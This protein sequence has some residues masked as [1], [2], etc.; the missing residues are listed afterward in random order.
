MNEDNLNIKCELISDDEFIGSSEFDFDKIIFDLNSQIDLLSSQADSLDYI[1]AIASGIV[2]GI[3]DI[4]WVGEFDLAHGRSIAS[5]KVDSFVKNTAEML[6]G[7]TFDD[8]KSAVQALEKHF[9]I[10]SDGNT[11]DFGGGKQHHL[12]DFAHHPTIVGLAFSL[13]TQFT[14]KSYGTDVNGRFITVDVPEKSKPFI[15]KD[16]PE[17]ILMGTIIWFFHLVSDIAGS[18]SAAGTTGGTGIPGPLLALAKEVSAIPFFKN[19]KVDD[20]MSMSLFLSKLFNGTLMMKRDEKGQ[21][22]KD[23]IIKFDLRGELGVAV[24]LCKQAVP[25]V[26]N[27]CF[28]RAFYFIRHLAMEMKENRV[29]CF[30]DMKMIDW[31]TVKPLNNPTIARMLTISTGVF[32][33]LDIGEAIATQKYWMSIN[34]VG[35]GRFAVAISSD[36]S[37]GLKARD[38]KKIRGVY[39]NIKHQTFGKTDAN[40]YKRIGDDMDLQMDKLGLSLEQTEILYNLEYYKTF[41]D[42]EMTKLPVTGEVIK[43]LK[44]EWL[45]EWSKFI[46]NGFESFTQI[47]G[48]EMH[49]Y[50]IDELQERIAANDPQK[51]WYRLILLE[52]MLFEPYYP[53]GTEKDKKGNDIPSK[54]YKHLN[55][56]LCSFRKG[57]GDR[58]LDEQFT[59]KYCKQGYVKRLRK[60]YDKRMRE[61]SEVLKTVLASLTI[62]AVI[63]II[64]VASAGA[65]AGPI[66]VALVGSN[67]AGLSG[68][69]LTSACLAYLGGGAIAAG[70]AGMLGGTI[71][72]VGGGAALG[73]GVGAGVG[74]A[75]GSAGLVGKKN[76][77]MQS[78]KLLTSVREIFLNDE[79]DIEFSNSV[80]EQYL[81]NITE[82]EKGLVELRLKMDVAKGKEKKEIA[83]TIKKAEESVEVMKVARKNMLRFNSSFAEG[84][85]TQQ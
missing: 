19:I 25:V 52:A 11:S 48:A 53:L 42:I 39:E 28:V 46:S 45:K 30:A 60:S 4:L 23:S 41:N 64:T 34:Y 14:E 29:V 24:E 27:E 16:I 7:K 15:G 58:F 26:A 75:V 8:V 31:D 67:F 22:V 33:V 62:T 82:I 56:P 5:D 66:A 65:F 76:T 9:L 21:I 68:A 50:S 85:Q 51:P 44:S 61:L 69:A 74:G 18:S 57:E 6:E 78:A 20:D 71:A 55:N 80:Y 70:G 1:V 84:L 40:I 73:I 59:G 2:C 12:R 17:K 77:I 3:L 38:V 54:K 36:V 10:P 35:I 13:L 63:A 83:E 81:Q 43:E 47:S 72:I 37:W 79:H 32:T 49:W